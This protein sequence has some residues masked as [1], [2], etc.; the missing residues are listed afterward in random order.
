M[1][2]CLFLYALTMKMSENV[3]KVSL[4]KEYAFSWPTKVKTIRQ[5]APYIM[6]KTPET[7][8]FI[9]TDNLF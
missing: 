5:A 4:R 7:Q 9:L 6:Q 2:E 8:K 3:V 1:E